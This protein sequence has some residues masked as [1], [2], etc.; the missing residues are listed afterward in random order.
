MLNTFCTIEPMGFFLGHMFGQ[1][2]SLD[3]LLLTPERSNCR[4]ETQLQGRTLS[5]GS[6][7]A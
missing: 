3:V 1:S 7:V 4:A 6:A 5:V 2:L